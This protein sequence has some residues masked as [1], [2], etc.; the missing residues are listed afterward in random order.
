MGNSIRKTLKKLRFRDVLVILTG[1]TITSIATQYLFDPSGLVT[2]GVSGL[3]IIIKYL[4][5]NGSSFVVPLW[6]SNLVLNVPIFLFAIKVFGFRSILRTGIAWLI[7]TIE[8]YF[9][10][11][12]GVVSDNLLLVSV[13]GGILFGVGS[14]LLLNVRSSTGGTDLLAASIQHYLRHYSVGTILQALDGTVVILGMLVFGIERTLYAIISVFIMGKVTDWIMSQGK[15]AKVVMIISDAS[16]S[17]AQNIM[18]DLDRGVTGLRG[19]GMYTGKDRLILLCICSR[20]DIPEV[21]DI[22]KEHDPRAFFIIS[23]A[24][25][26]MGEGFIEKWT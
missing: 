23:D 6:L 4:T 14:G 5:G 20:R 21:K 3:A 17:I 1:S 7:M 12:F 19:K 10:P 18:E 2:G 16:E 15:T 11:S 13:Y 24:T 8:L 26:A 9:F 25:E 22:V